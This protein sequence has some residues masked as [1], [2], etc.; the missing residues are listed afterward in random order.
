MWLQQYNTHERDF[1]TKNAIYTKSEISTHSSVTVTRM[2]VDMTLTSVTTTRSSVIYTH[3]NMPKR[4]ENIQLI[5]YSV[6]KFTSRLSWKCL[7][8]FLTKIWSDAKRLEKVRFLSDWF[9]LECILLFILHYFY[10][11]IY[12]QPC[13]SRFIQNTDII[14]KFLIYPELRSFMKIK[15]TAHHNGIN[16]IKNIVHKLILPMA[17]IHKKKDIKKSHMWKQ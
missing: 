2:R 8:S 3:S 5:V 6:I 1:Y 12:F 14:R 15:Y 4:P 16:Y 17:I 11:D 7:E 9:Q 13:I 10:H